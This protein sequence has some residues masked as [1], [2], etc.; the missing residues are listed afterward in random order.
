MNKPS[1]SAE[2]GRPPLPFEPDPPSWDTPLNE[3]AAPIHIEGDTKGIY[4]DAGNRI[5]PTFWESVCQRLF[6]RD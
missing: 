5:K 4:D 2:K 1:R 3:T 6:R